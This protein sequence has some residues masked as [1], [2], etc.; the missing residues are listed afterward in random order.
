[1]TQ[2]GGSDCGRSR[3]TSQE[4]G[5]CNPSRGNGPLYLRST[6]AS[7]WSALSLSP[8]CLFLWCLRTA[9]QYRERPQKP[10]AHSRQRRPF[11]VW[12]EGVR[13]EGVHLTAE[14]PS[15]VRVFCD[16]NCSNYLTPDPD[17]ALI[18]FFF[19]GCLSEISYW[20]ILVA[21]FYSPVLQAHAETFLCV[22]VIHRTLAWTT[23]PLA[24]LRHYSYA[25]VYTRGVGSTDSSAAFLTRK[26]SLSFSCAADWIRTRVS[27]VE[28]ELRRSTNQ[29]SHTATPLNF[30]VYIKF[31]FC[32][33]RNTT[34]KVI[35]PHK[36]E[37]WINDRLT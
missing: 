14:E 18:F 28:C 25:C 20:F 5:T 9:V 1:M 31:C 21:Y 24:R 10:G 33:L 7:P 4:Q 6:S 29:M 26:N 8:L 15:E 12:G 36:K 2:V 16:L 23:G 30:E 37:F 3:G 27:Y 22:S 13:V 11:R 17:L 32:Q 19:F 34:S 35:C